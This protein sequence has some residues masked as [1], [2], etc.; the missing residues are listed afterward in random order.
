MDKGNIF[1]VH[2]PFLELLGV[3]AELGEGGHSRLSLELRPELLNHLGVSHG[4]VMMTLLDVAMAVAARTSHAR[5]MG[6]IT[7]DMS[8]NFLR[9]GSGRLIAEGH[10][11]RGGRSL[12]FCEGEVTDASGQRVAKALGTF[13]LRERAP[14]EH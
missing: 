11:L 13:K 14:K 9:G 7:V 12:H 5:P 8:I 10:L 6:V 3:S 1:G 4:G 2:V